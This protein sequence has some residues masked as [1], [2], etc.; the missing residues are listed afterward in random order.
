MTR[1]EAID[2]LKAR[3]DTLSDDRVAAL[4]EL[5]SAWSRPTVYSTLPD[6]EKAEIDAALDELDRGEG[7]PWETVSADLEAKIK[8]A[9]A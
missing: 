6:A 5:A 4:A 8:A 9:G 2:T 3:I 1:T 7:I